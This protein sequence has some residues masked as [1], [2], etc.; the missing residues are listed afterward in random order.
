MI[1]WRYFFRRG[2]NWFA[3]SLILLFVV[4]AILAPWLA[5]PDDPEN[6]TPFQ[7]PVETEFRFLVDTWPCRTAGAATEG[8]R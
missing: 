2:Q 6:N 8:A 5:P 3:I 4:V 7:A 1:R